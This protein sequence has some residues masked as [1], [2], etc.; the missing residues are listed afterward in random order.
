MPVYKTQ[1]DKMTR[2]PVQR[3][4]FSLGIPTTLSMLVTTLYNMVDTYFVAQI[5]TSATGA[6]GVVFALMAI[7]QAFGFMLGHGAGSNISRHLGAKNVR[8]ARK[9]ASTSFYLALCCGAVIMTVGLLCLTPLMRLLGSTPTILP[10]ARTYGVYI[11]LGAPAMA[12]GCVLNNIMRYEGRAVY[13]MLGL[14]SG[15]LLNILGDWLLM[16]VLGMGIEG[17]GIATAVSQYVSL[18]VLLIPFFRRRVQS[19]L[20]VRYI[21]RQWKDVGN[22]VAVGMPSMVRQGLNSIS[23]TALNWQA[24]LYGGDAAVAAMSIVMRICSFIF[25]IGLGIGQGFQPVSAFNYGA[26]KYSRV[27]AGFLFTVKFGLAFLGVLSLAGFIWA[28][29]LVEMFRSDP[30]VVQMGTFALKAQSVAFLFLP[31]SV[32]GNMLFQSIGKSGYATFLACLRS[33]LCFIPLILV[34]PLF[35]G[36]TGIQLAQP[37]A[38]VLATLFTIPFLVKFFRELPADAPAGA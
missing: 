20:S 11:L 9:F 8:D 17:A 2:M 16:G 24:A 14:G 38:D 25:C 28:G 3:L 37:I 15:A 33:G 13:A 7:I 4:V 18:T 19:R 35:M 30:Q 34:L 6:T 32:C 27:R 21:T 12:A 31:V 29:P 22:I 1:Y 5:G 10:Y 26:R 36:V 23:T